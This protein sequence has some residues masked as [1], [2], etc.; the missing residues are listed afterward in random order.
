MILLRLAR[1]STLSFPVLCSKPSALPNPHP[2]TLVHTF[3]LSQETLDF[4]PEPST[5]DPGGEGP[6]KSPTSTALMRMKLGVRGGGGGGPAGGKS[7]Q[8]KKQQRGFSMWTL[9][10]STSKPLSVVPTTAIALLDTYVVTVAK[11]FPDDA[12]VQV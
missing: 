4:P 1:P 8:Q 10:E 3:F 9:H 7:K 2:N 6:P 11:R 5:S 12:G